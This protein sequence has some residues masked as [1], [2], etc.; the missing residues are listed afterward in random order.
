MI[1]NLLTLSS[2]VSCQV[3]HKPY[4]CVCVIFHTVTKQIYIHIQHCLI[5]KLPV[6][7]SVS[8]Y[9]FMIFILRYSWLYFVCSMKHC[10]HNFL[11][12]CLSPRS[13]WQLC[14][15][16]LMVIQSRYCAIDCI[17]AWL[18]LRNCSSKSF[19]GWH[20]QKT[21]ILLYQKSPIGRMHNYYIREV[22]LTLHY[23]GF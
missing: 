5:F 6:C 16:H 18:Y 20:L 22:C 1:A 7:L 17:L 3:Y 12:V 10:L 9:L 23:S 2:C 14:D 21:N 8:I 15:F 11:L 13:H 19:V 4:S